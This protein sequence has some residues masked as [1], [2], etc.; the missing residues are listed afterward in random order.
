MSLLEKN[1]ILCEIR[2]LLTAASSRLDTTREKISEF[3][4]VT[5]ETVQTS[6]ERKKI[7]VNEQSISD[8]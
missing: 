5:G 3:V 7:R 2:I 8:L 1:N 6:T 4:G